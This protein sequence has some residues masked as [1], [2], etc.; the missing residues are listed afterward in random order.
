MNGIFLTA[1]E[2]PI[3]KYIVLVMG[4]LIEAVFNFLSSVGF[5]NIGLSIIIFTVIIYLFLTPVTYQQQKFSKLSA[6]M[7]PELKKIQEKYKGRRD[8]AGMQ[9]MQAE[10]NNVY[11]KY[12]VN[13]MGSC[14]QMAIQLP[15]LFAL[16]QVIYKLP[17]YVAQIRAAFFPLVD[18][19]IGQNGSAEFL[20]SFESAKLFSKQFTSE[21]FVSGNV[22]YIQNTYIDVLNRAS[23]AEWASIA[24]KFP[25]LASDVASSVAKLLE[26]NTFLGGLNIAD[27]PLFTIKT[28]FTAGNFLLIIIAALIPILAAVTQWLN[29]KLMPQ[30]ASSGDPNA[31]AMTQQMKTMNTFMPLVSAFF[32]LQFPAGMGIYWVASAVVRSV[33]QV[34]INKQIDKIDFDE[35]VKKNEEKLKESGALKK[36][37]EDPVRLSAIAQMSLKRGYRDKAE[38]SLS[39]TDEELDKIL[40]EKEEYYRN[41]RA[42][43]ITEKANLVRRYNGE[44]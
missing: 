20:Q 8:E 39:M 12:G 42:G 13:P 44:F 6:K 21:A 19:L 38:F 35:V 31:D 17:A 25:S 36:P 5:P 7:N 2:V 4:K 3:F 34:I 22:E 24:E 23:S 14:A 29:F 41:A 15:I 40:A 9:A 37:E 16:Y 33:Q 30:P 11:K 28:A 18:N 27:S 32:C 43:T 26:Y 1:N 10:T